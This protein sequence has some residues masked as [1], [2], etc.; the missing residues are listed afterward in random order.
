MYGVFWFFSAD[1]PR[2]DNSEAVGVSLNLGTSIALIAAG[3]A[4]IDQVAYLAIRVFK[5]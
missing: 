3:Y 4:G 1:S 2:W 5:A